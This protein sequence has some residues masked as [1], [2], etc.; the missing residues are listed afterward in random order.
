MP[1]TSYIDFAVRQ[2]FGLELGGKMH[3][4]QVSWDVFNLANL[5]NPSWGV[6]YSIPGDFNNYFLYYFDGYDTDGT[7]PMFTY[8]EENIGTDA[9]NIADFS[10]RWRMRLGLRYIFN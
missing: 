10:S 6:R 1:F 4:F 7:T 5:I 2:D 3:K 8:S 9:L